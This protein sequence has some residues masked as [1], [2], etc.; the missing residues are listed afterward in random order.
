MAVR[1]LTYYEVYELT[2]N[3]K[4]INTVQ[5]VALKRCMYFKNLHDPV[6]LAGNFGTLTAAQRK[7]YLFSRESLEAGTIGNNVGFARNYAL[8]LLYDAV[9]I[10]MEDAGSAAWNPQGVTDEL[11]NSA[12]LSDGHGTMADIWQVWVNQNSG[13]IQYYT[14]LPA[15]GLKVKNALLKAATEVIGEGTGTYPQPAVDKRHALAVQILSNPDSYVST[16]KYSI[17]SNVAIHEFSTESDIEFTVNSMFNDFAGVTAG[18][19]V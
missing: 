11:V 18:D 19:L 7:E 2:R 16:L 17:A 1:T 15:F 12:I 10:D 9:G 13:S 6:V 3:E 14:E 8:K 5:A 4:F